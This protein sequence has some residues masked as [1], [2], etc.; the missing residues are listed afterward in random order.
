V[1]APDEAPAALV[2]GRR[3]LGGALVVIGVV[4]ILAGAFWYFVVPYF[5]WN[6]EGYWFYLSEFDF[7]GI[8]LGILGI[9]L[10]ALGLALI[11]RARKRRFK[12]FEGGG[13]IATL[14][15][16]GRSGSGTP[17]GT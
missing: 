15:L 13:S 14:D 9:V 5:G 6:M 7:G 17:P 1:S 11:Q 10:A 2:A 12:V 3:V 8:V 16:R 4:A